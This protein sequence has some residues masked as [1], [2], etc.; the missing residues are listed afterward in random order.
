[1]PVEV[2][3]DVAIRDEQQLRGGDRAI[4]RVAKDQHGVVA[5]RQ[6]LALGLSPQ[7]IGRRL[8]RGRLHM[9]HRG[10]YAVGHTAITDEGRW[11]AAVLAA[12]SRSVLSH[13]SAA[14]LWGL[15]KWDGRWPEVT[16]VGAGTRSPAGVRLH[17]TA[18]LEPKDVRRRA[19]IPVTSPART[20]I[21]IA[22]QLSY[23]ALR[24]AVRQA[25]SL[26]LLTMRDLVEALCRLG[27]RRGAGKLRRIVADGPA[28]TRSLLEDVVLDLIKAAGLEQP[29]VNVPIY[30]DGRKVI[31]DFRWP[32]RRLVVEA[33]GAAWHD[34]PLA[35]EADAERQAL[36]EAHGERVIRVTWDQAVRHPSQTMDRL[37][38]AAARSSP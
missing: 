38:A 16:I 8:T 23:L 13:Y 6:L 5:R 15:V 7:A 28:P 2:A 14:A 17:R 25:L 20:L 31:P 10:I 19:G 1:M 35:R 29:D 27:H 26:R 34:N 32:E 24:R 21:D 37:G 36:L 30:L 22:S 4:A 11:L 33:D 9:L 18:Q 3:V 12:G